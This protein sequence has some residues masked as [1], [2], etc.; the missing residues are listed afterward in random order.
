MSIIL[1]ITAVLTIIA[2]AIS[3]FLLNNNNLK[4]SDIVSPAAKEE[5]LKKIAPNNVTIVD[6]K[7]V[8][9]ISAKGGYSPQVTHAKADIP[10]IIK[11]VTN[12]T[13]D[14]SSALSIPS[15]QYQK[16]LPATGETL[17]DVPAQSTGTTLQGVCS[18]GMYNF[19][20]LFE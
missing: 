19:S 20:I 3:I 4:R 14:C 8:I 1:K 15:L 10:T 6:E 13:F 5:A 17:I 7:Q 12:G 9:T 18:M 16:N 11:V 2:A